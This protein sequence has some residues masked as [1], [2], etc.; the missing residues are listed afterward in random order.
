MKTSLKCLAGAVTLALSCSANAGI[1]DLFTTDQAKL[2]DTTIGGIV[3]SSVVDAAP[4]IE[5]LGEERDLGVDLIFSSGPGAESSIQVIGSELQFA[6]NPTARSLGIVQWDGKDSSIVL[7]EDGL[8]GIDLTEGGTVNAFLVETLFS[9][10]DWNFELG[11]YTDASNWTKINFDATPVFGATVSTILFAGFTNSS[12]CG[13]T[14]PALGVLSV[15]C[16]PSNQV[17]NL[18]KLGA[19]EL[20]LNTAPYT[21][22]PSGSNGLAIDLRLANV[23]TVPEPATIGLF[24]AGLLAIG[25]IGRRRKEQSLKA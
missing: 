22:P 21:A 8:G 11:L 14:N 23:T 16:A 10:L 3:S 18:T 4:P 5:I 13:S 1:I 12:L 19:I 2:T 15:S 24:G 7:D 17:V 25:T 9:D 6:N 20:K